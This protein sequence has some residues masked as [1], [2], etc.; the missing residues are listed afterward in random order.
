MNVV[1]TGPAT[2]FDGSIDQTSGATTGGAASTS[3]ADNWVGETVALEALNGGCYGHCTYGVENP[4]GQGAYYT[5]VINEAQASFALDGRTGVRNAIILLGNGDANAPASDLP[6]GAAVNQCQ[7][8]I[9]AAMSAE[10]QGTL[11]FAVAY[12][13]S[14]TSGCATDTTAYSVTYAGVPYAVDAPGLSSAC[15]M[16]LMVDNPVTDSTLPDTGGTTITANDVIQI[17]GTTASDPAMHFYFDARGSDLQP[18]FQSIADSLSSA[19]L[20]SNNAT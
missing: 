11:F 12:G 15:A 1:S 10:K 7:Q 14:T 8:A 2:G 16:K 5:N 9:A 17:C 13:S 4:G 19:R 3:T 20:V 6:A 18:D